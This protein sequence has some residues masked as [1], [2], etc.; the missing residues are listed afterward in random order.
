L[1]TGGN[2]FRVQA[3]AE[4]TIRITPAPNRLRIFENLVLTERPI[5]NGEGL[6]RYTPPHEASL[7]RSG[8]GA[9]KDL[10]FVAD[11]PGGRDA[12]SRLSFYLPVYRA[13]YGQ[14][15]YRGG[16]AV[17]LSAILAALALIWH[18]NRRFPWR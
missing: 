4:L 10:L 8:Y 12:P 11:L 6:Y 17:L 16:L 7:S 13:F 9:K 14:I 3:G 2:F 1:L 5:V 18:W 15:S